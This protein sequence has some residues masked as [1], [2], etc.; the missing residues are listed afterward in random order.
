MDGELYSHSLGRSPVWTLTRVRC[1]KP[2][3][4]DIGAFWLQHGLTRLPFW[5]RIIHNHSDFCS[6]PPQHSQSLPALSAAD[7]L[8]SCLVHRLCH[9][10]KYYLVP[11]LEQ[12]RMGPY[13][14]RP[15]SLTA[16][17][18]YLPFEGVSSASFAS[19]LWSRW[20]HRG[21]LICL[22]EWGGCVKILTEVNLHHLLLSLYPFGRWSS[23]RRKWDRFNVISFDI[24][25]LA[26]F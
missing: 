26:V 3:G 23:Q 11:D 1:L 15:P 24:A 21:A 14:P 8:L 9:W 4:L 7:F 17:C 18:C 6:Y 12:T 19:V 25:T 5:Q 16:K 10:W 20:N 2:D 22:W 13:W